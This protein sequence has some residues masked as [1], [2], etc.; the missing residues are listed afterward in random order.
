MYLLSI[1]SSTKNFALA[2]SRDDKVLR[3][4]NLKV[5]KILEN[6]IIGAI[7]RVLSSAGVPFEKLDAFAVGL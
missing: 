4:R 3:Y 1:E 2:V 7:D 5:H 6:A